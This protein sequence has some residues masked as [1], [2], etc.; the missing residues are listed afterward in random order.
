MA[1][2]S[3]ADFEDLQDLLD[4][5]LQADSFF[6]S[7]FKKDAIN[8]AYIDIAKVLRLGE[9]TTATDTGVQDQQEY[10]WPS[11]AMA[12]TDVTYDDNKISKESHRSILSRA[13]SLTTADTQGIV[14][15]YYVTKNRKVGL[16]RV[17]NES[18]KTIK[19]YYLKYPALMTSNSDVPIVPLE[20]RMAIVYR[21]AEKCYQ[22]AREW[23]TSDRYKQMWQNLLLEDVLVTQEEEPNF[24]EYIDEYDVE[25]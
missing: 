7:D 8:Q 4:R 9:N 10:D 13:S 17:P 18:G 1:Q 6:S 21:A 5:E 23:N 14:E 11:D 25:V 12:I 19:F 20:S 22:T 3:I 16:W 15:R 2:N 24:I